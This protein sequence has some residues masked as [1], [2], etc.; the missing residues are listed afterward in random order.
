MIVKSVTLPKFTIE[1]KVHNAYNRKNIVQNKINYDPVTIQFRD[2]QSDNVRQFWYDYYSYFYRDPDYADSTYDIQHKY[3]SRPT[4]DWGYSPRPAVGYSSSSFNQ[5]YQYIQAV[6]IYSLFQGQF[7]EYQ[8]I[9]P[10]ITKFAHGDHDVSV[11]DVMHHD[12]TLQ[13]EAVKY[14]TGS[15][16]ENTVGGYIELLYDKTPSP[17]DNGQQYQ[18]NTTEIVD[19]ANASTTGIGV[20][21]EAPVFGAPASASTPATLNSVTTGMAGSGSSAGGYT[22]PSMSALTGGVTGTGVLTQQLKSAGVNLVGSATGQ[23]ANGI[24]GAVAAGLGS[25]GQTIVGLAAAAIANPSQA[26]KTVE[27]MATSLALGIGMNFVNQGI[28]SAV[29]GISGG[30]TRG[31]DSGLGSLNKSLSFGDAPDFNTAVSQSTN[32]LM[33]G[34]GFNTNAQLFAQSQEQYNN[35]INQTGPYAIITDPAT[36]LTGTAAQLY[37]GGGD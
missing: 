37:G 24:K 36:G 10:T 12:M 16:T 22:I 34:F 32:N 3:Q 14:L 6:R 4:F 33:N 20:G 21:L 5:P 7:S 13:Y 2:D 25:N 8:L 31:I 26:L 30:I 29:Q 23:L 19:L 9:N 28:A 1:T 27:N 17:L 35:I 18:T 11:N 15:V